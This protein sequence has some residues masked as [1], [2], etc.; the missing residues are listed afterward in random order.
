[1]SL[2]AEGREEIARLA[3][4]GVGAPEGFITKASLTE[5]MRGVLERDGID[6]A[7][8]SLE[9]LMRRGFEVARESGASMSPFFGSGLS[10][11]AEPESGEADGW[12]IYPEELIERI[13]TRQE[14]GDDD[15]GPQLLAAKSG[16]R[17]Q[18]KH[19]AW[20][21]GAQGVVTDAKG[22]R[23]PI[24]HGYQEGLTSEEMAAEA[25]ASGAAPRRPTGCPW[26]G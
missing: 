21:A 4:T 7:L 6:A 16:A 11:P 22:R 10:F 8:Q 20:I 26:S 19:L 13:A 1:L 17:G 14:F 5:A 3:G 12:E 2:T 18:V 15:L 23:V 24:R 9:R 25:G